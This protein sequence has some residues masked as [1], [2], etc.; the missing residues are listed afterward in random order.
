LG[1]QGEVTGVSKLLD[2]LW[3]EKILIFPLIFEL[4]FALNLNSVQGLNTEISLN[5]NS[6]T[7]HCA[8]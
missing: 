3:I 8:N 2:L 7:L 1:T 4:F 6:N 5:L